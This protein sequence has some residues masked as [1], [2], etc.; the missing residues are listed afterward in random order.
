MT[1]TI[2]EE[3]SHAFLLSLYHTSIHLFYSKD[4]QGGKCIFPAT[5]MVIVTDLH[6]HS[7]SISLLQ[8]RKS[9]TDA[10]FNTTLSVMS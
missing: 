6:L 4:L 2:S 9:L 7:A 1:G 8:D 5:T 3:Y 10:L